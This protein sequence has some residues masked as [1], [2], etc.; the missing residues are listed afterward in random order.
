MIWLSVA[1][2]HILAIV[3]MSTVTYGWIMGGAHTPTL[4]LVALVAVWD[5][6][7]VNFM[8][9]AT[10]VD[11]DLANGIAGADLVQRHR[12]RVAPAR[13]ERPPHASPVQGEPPARHVPHGG[14]PQGGQGPPFPRIC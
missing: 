3:F 9:K 2:P 11:E 7:I 14:T 1:R 10:D 8:N 4:L 5:W 12:R 6:F 13:R